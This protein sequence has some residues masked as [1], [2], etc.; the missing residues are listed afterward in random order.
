MGPTSKWFVKLMA[1]AE[2][3]GNGRLRL[4]GRS[5]IV[6]VTDRAQAGRS[7]SVLRGDCGDS[8]GALP[9]AGDCTFE[10]RLG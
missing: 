2:E 6:E 9:A 1:G 4:T 5:L 7:R 10:R 3:A 8:P